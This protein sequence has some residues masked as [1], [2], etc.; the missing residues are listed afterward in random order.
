M[1]EISPEE[2]Q[3]RSERARQLHAEGKFGG[4]QHGAKGG[5]PRKKRASEIVAAKAEEQ[6]DEIVA[7]FLRGVRD[8]DAKTAVMAAE[9]WLRV[10]NQEAELQLKE[11]KHL[12]QLS[13]DDLIARLAEGFARLKRAGID[14]DGADMVVDLDDDAVHEVASRE[15]T[16][17]A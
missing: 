17:G 9:K 10:E 3:R 6:A 13:R 14:F 7:A 11:Q 5:R 2:R 16:S 4:A 12:D 8:P 15:L 1:A